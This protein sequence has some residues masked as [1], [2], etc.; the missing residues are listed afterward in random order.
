MEKLKGRTVVIAGVGWLGKAVAKDLVALNA[1]VI[2]LTRYAEDLKN[3]V[4]SEVK[5]VEWKLKN[6]RF[7]TEEQFD[8]PLDLVIALPPT[9]FSVYSESILSILELFPRVE[10]VVFCSS[11]GVYLNLPLI[12]DESGEVNAN[13]VVFQAERKLHELHQ[14]TTV[15]RLAGLIGK[16]RH[17]VKHLMN[18]FNLDGDAPVNLVHQKDVVQAILVVLTSQLSSK[19]FNVSFPEHPSRGE[20]YGK[21][22]HKLFGQ[23]CLFEPG[24]DG[25]IVVGDFL[26][27]VSDF[28]YK[29]SIWNEN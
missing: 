22:A 4:P 21:M 5:I 29:H 25:K 24:G 14:N 18:R 9:R 2:A 12:I 27:Q 3:E 17:P 19:L 23:K 16:G 28:Q 26:T 10:K 7:V 20:Y 8:F 15:L 6:E 1:K 13:H 11:I